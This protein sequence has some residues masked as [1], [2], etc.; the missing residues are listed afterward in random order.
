MV[1]ARSEFQVLARVL[2]PDLQSS[3]TPLKLVDVL[4][5]VA[6]QF[7]D[8]LETMNSM[9]LDAMAQGA[10]SIDGSAQA[11]LVLGEYADLI[12]DALGVE[13]DVGDQTLLPL[14]EPPEGLQQGSPVKQWRLAMAPIANHVA[15]LAGSSVDPQVAAKLRVLAQMKH[16]LSPIDGGMATGVSSK[17][18]T[19]MGKGRLLDTEIIAIY[20]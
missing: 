20:W 4:A 15:A 16:G 12:A 9:V 10:E 19:A 17:P 2:R 13:L 8:A 1:F 18:G 14:L 3:W 5:R 6:P 7:H 11:R